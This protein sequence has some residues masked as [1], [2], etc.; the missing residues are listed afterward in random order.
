MKRKRTNYP[1]IDEYLEE[2]SKLKTQ[3]QKNNRLVK[4]ADELEAML[5]GKMDLAAWEELINTVVFPR[6]RIE[7]YALDKKYLN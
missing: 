7:K 5:G 6:L 3:T 4:L 2:I 1:Y